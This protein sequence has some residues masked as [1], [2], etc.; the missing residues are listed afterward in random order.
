VFRLV[1]PGREVASASVS[2]SRCGHP[3]RIVSIGRLQGASLQEDPGYSY[4]FTQP[5]RA[6]AL[7]LRLSAPQ[8]T[9]APTAARHNIVI[10]TL[11]STPACLPAS[12]DETRRDISAGSA[13]GCGRSEVVASKH[14]VLKPA[15]SRAAVAESLA[16]TF[17][18]LTTTPARLALSLSGHQ[19]PVALSD[20]VVCPWTQFALQPARAL[21]SRP[22]APSV[23][24]HAQ[25][26]CSKHRSTRSPARAKLRR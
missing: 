2:V 23:Q 25:R 15:L 16:L 3:H 4:S 12:T 6:L 1:V 24:L 9:V 20:P 19:H 10:R 8:P 14:A 21:P 17:C 7:S 22:H 13:C 5:L 11:C 26:S 18:S